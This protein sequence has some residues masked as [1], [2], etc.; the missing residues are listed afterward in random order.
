MEFLVGHHDIPILFTESIR[1]S[2]TGDP[3]HE[4]LLASRAVFAWMVV[5]LDAVGSPTLGSVR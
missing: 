1:R 2:T 3:S 4:A 5:I